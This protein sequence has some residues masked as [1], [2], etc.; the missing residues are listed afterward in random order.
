MAVPLKRLARAGKKGTGKGRRKGL[1]TVVKQ[2]GVAV[3]ALAL[4]LALVGLGFYL[5]QKQEGEQSML[6]QARI[7]AEGVANRLSEY[8]TFHSSLLAR[9]AQSPGLAELLQS[10]NRDELMAQEQGLLR[11]MQGALR[12]RFLPLEWDSPDPE[13]RPPFSFASLEMIRT[14]E[15]S[16]LSSPAEVHQPGSPHRHL[17]LA[18]P[19]KN[20]DAVLVGVAHLVLA[21]EVLQ[22]NVAD[23]NDPAGQFVVQQVIANG[24]V[25]L[26]SNKDEATE[27]SAAGQVPVPGSIWQVAYWPSEPAGSLLQKPQFWGILAGGLVLI[28]L[29]L[30]LLSIRFGR[31]FEQ[32]TAVVTAAAVAGSNATL[33]QNE[34][35]TVGARESDSSDIEKERRVALAGKLEALKPK[36]AK[37]VSPITKVSLPAS[38]FRA[39]DIRGVVDETLDADSVYLI[40]RA[41]GSAAQEQGQQTVIIGRDGR[42]SSQALSEALARG[43]ME[44]GRDVVDLGQVP[45][46]VLYFAT[47]F[48]GSDSG[49]IVTGSHNPPEYN[50]LKIVIGGEALSGQ[51]IQGLRQRI[52]SGDLLQGEGVLQE[53]DL[54]PDYINRI[55]EDVQLLAPLKVVVDCGNGVASVAAPI[56]FQ[57]LGCEVTDLFCEV[58]GNFPNHHPDPGN[59]EN[60][61]ALVEKVREQG[62]DL[63]LAFDGDG[64]RLGVVDSQGKIIWPDRLLMLLA[65]D[66]L[67]RQPGADVVYDVK[68]SRHLAGE[69]LTAGGRPIMWRSGHSLIKAKMKETDALLGGELSGHIYIK[70]R[71]YGF[72]DALYAGARLLEIISAEGLSSAEVFA[73][74]PES[75]STMELSSPTPEAARLMERLSEQFQFPRAKLITIDGIRAEFEDGWGLVRPSNTTPMIMFRFEAD[76]EAAL[77]RIQGIFREQISGIAPELELPF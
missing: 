77:A 16:G 9:Y 31:T 43:L 62:A 52:E 17:A 59:P 66:I 69:I 41:I 76:D 60:M 30:S 34:A 10:E 70:D 3:I 45:T 54:L 12:V 19:I 75:V 24:I 15:Q 48:L 49:V 46:P 47:H 37:P 55:I 74:L 68:S 44:S 26:A 2:V 6:E 1:G 8:V 4:V 27:G 58:N 40:G 7:G 20:R 61:R 67:M 33:H 50:G 14:V 63:G 13:A 56:L 32:K 64:D 65:R 73:S 23:R 18:A 42:L 51:R 38:I 57:A 71:W 36:T 39:Y 25:N 21:F 11:L 22:R 5:L 53:Q 72:D 35:V 28:G 29:L